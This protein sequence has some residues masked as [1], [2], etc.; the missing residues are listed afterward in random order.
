MVMPRSKGAI[1]GL[2]L[3]LLGIWGALIPFVGPYFDFGYGS[4]TTWAWTS[5]RFWY[6]VLPGI[7][8]FAGGLLLLFSANRAVAHVGAWAAAASGAWFIL[9]P[10]FAPELGLGDLGSPMNSGWVRVLTS[11][12]LFFGLGLAILYFAATALGRLSVKGVRDVRAAEGRHVDDRHVDGRHMD[13]HVDDHHVDDHHVDD[14]RVAGDPRMAAGETTEAR[15][16]TV[17]RPGDSTRP[18]PARSAH[19]SETGELSETGATRRRRHFLR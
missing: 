19:D 2:M 3:V 1:S 8:T 12:G 9:G 6:E 14:H 18:V 15:D 5:A 4:D 17:A 10:V 7:V 16:E 11:I 13:D